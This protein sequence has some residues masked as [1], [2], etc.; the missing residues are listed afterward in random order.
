VKK[1]L[2]IQVCSTL[3]PQPMAQPLSRASALPLVLLVLGLFTNA[4]C[5]V[6]LNSIRRAQLHSGIRR[7]GTRLGRHVRNLDVT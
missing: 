1:L 3:N 4:N 7:R 6:G 2:E 5:Q